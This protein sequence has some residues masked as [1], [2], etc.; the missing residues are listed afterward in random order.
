MA[1]TLSDDAKLTI[2]ANLTEARKKVGWS[3]MEA[4]ERAAVGRTR[5]NLWEKGHELPGLDGLMRLAVTYGCPIDDF[6]G[7]VDE[8]YDAIIERRV[9]PN[10]RQFY[11]ARE[12]QIMRMQQA[13]MRLALNEPGSEPTREETAGGGLTTGEK[14]AT[15][16]TRRRRG[17]K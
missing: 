14:G 15:T 4:A 13:M 12:A 6:L 1:R 16:R 11:R 10:W 8:A 5:L 3:Q 7:A 17:K 2:G 9:P